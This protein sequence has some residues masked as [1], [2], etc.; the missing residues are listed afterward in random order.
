MYTVKTNTGREVMN[1]NSKQDAI[2]HAK[3]ILMNVF[4]SQT[5]VVDDTSGEVTDSFKKCHNPDGKYTRCGG[6]PF[7][8]VRAW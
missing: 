6:R 4:V 5:F 3:A 2:H 8:I 7:D 1:I